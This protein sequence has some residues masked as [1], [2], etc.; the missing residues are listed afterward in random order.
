MS[1]IY[2][3]L[4]GGPD[5]AQDPQRLQLLAAQ[6]RRREG[7]GNVLAMSGDAALSPVGKS[8]AERAN[9]QAE[10]IGREHFQAVDDAQTKAYQD[11]QIK[12]WN[13][14]LQQRNS[15]FERQQ[16]LAREQMRNALEIAGIRASKPTAYRNLTDKS[17]STLD[18]MNTANMILDDMTSYLDSGHS[19]GSSNPLQYLVRTGARIAGNVGL[20]EYLP[21]DLEQANLMWQNYDKLYTLIQRHN[22]FGSALTGQE[23]QKWKEANPSMG[24]SDARIRAGMEIIKK[25]A[26]GSIRNRILAEIANGANPDAVMALT[27][28]LTNL[29]SDIL[30]SNAKE[31]GQQSLL[32]N[33]ESAPAGV[34]ASPAPS[35]AP[36]PAPTPAGGG[37][38]RRMKFVNGKLVPQ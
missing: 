11:A 27:P 34:P 33:P 32:A 15:E 36:A 17:K 28:S 5:P 6:L 38:T 16:Q 1:D 2:Q 29:S 19:L 35:P 12:Y 24:Q 21:A 3:A 9:S 22:L 14:Q 23:G 26:R 7:M 30:A 25:Y 4:L 8:L 18:D 13:D 20:G 10:Q 37:A 31:Q